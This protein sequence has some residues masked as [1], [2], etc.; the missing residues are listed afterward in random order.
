MKFSAPALLFLVPASLAALAL[1][2]AA[3][4]GNSVEAGAGGA[5]G[6]SSTT[7]GGGKGGSPAATT[8]TTGATTATT[9]AG[10]GAEPPG[11]TPGAPAGGG[12]GVVLALRQL[13]LGDTDRD[14]TLDPTNGWKQYGFDLDGQ[15]TLDLANH[16]TPNSGAS[17]TVFEKGNDGIDNSFG[18]NV[19]STIIY[20]FEPSAGPTIDADLD[21]GKFTNLFDIEK[22]GPGPSY[23][24]L[25]TLLYGGA[26]LGHAPLWDGS[27]KWP[28]LPEELT[29]PMDITSAKTQ[30][31]MS[32]LSEG[33][34]V[35]G[36]KGDIVLPLPVGG[37]SLTLTIHNAQV[38]M[39]L[40]A[41][42]TS[43]TNG[44]IAGVLDTEEFVAVV[45]QLIGQLV[46]SLCGS[47]TL[48]TVLA[49]IRQ[50][51]DIMQ[52]G[53][54]DP[55]QVCDG[56]SIG[57]GFNAAAVQLGAIAPPE[58]PPTNACP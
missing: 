24:G 51:S 43:A 11:P 50:A 1:A 22:L 13:F 8:A 19:F 9:G 57:L 26:N 46:P 54:Q 45:Q 7:G 6:T 2:P 39:D 53:T 4:C 30:F 5:D 52:D 58:P 28:V 37:G 10:G 29:N 33:V 23:S 40:D 21:A 34:W 25:L 32:Y 3:G 41:S 36:S 12:A 20:G 47:A 27:D 55:T 17:P 42:H 35:S 31:P 49:S 48:T 15:T 38:A 14:G 16:C 18:H 56:V 44:T